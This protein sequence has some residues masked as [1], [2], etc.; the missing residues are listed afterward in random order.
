MRQYA[1]R[2]GSALTARNL[3]SSPYYIYTR[4]ALYALICACVV[5]CASAPKEEE[6][7]WIASPD[8]EYPSA[9]YI[10]GLGDGTT[11]QEAKNNAAAEISRQLHTHVESIISTDFA[12][13]TQHGLH[14]TTRT[15]TRNVT[16]TSGIELSGLSYTQP[17]LRKAEKTWYC[18]ASISRKTAWTQFQKQIDQSREAFYAVYN[19]MPKDNPIKADVWYSRAQDAADAF[20]SQLAF[21]SAIDNVRERT[22]YAADRTVIAELPVRLDELH[23]LITLRI[24]SSPDFPGQLRTEL[25]QTLSS[26]GF[27]LT[28][29][30][31]QYTAQVRLDYNEQAAADS[32]DTIYI[33]RP[34][35]TLELYNGNTSFCTCSTAQNIKAVSFTRSD[36]QRRAVQALTAAVR[37][38]FKQ[39]FTSVLAGQAL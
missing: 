31:A 21:A 7:A 37:A 24:A 28:D 17:Y 11:K 5:S 26:M 32:G 12:A 2:G 36:A 29:T 6:P 14:D 34:V 18:L 39:T 15:T 8:T 19:N 23:Q 9:A 35:L 16:I 22:D 20:L 1:A 30:G 4:R 3:F 10:T 33:E 25:S 13:R 27:H 38:D